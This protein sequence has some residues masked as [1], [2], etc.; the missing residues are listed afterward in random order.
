MFVHVF[1]KELFYKPDNVSV[2]CLE[3]GSENGNKSGK[4]KKMKRKEAARM[5]V[6]K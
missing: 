6:H 3:R 4:R 5:Q 2:Y 1:K